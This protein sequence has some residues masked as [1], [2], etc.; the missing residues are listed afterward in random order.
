M[1][2]RFDEAVQ[3]V[4]SSLILEGFNIHLLVKGDRI[5]VKN[6]PINS[7]VEFEVTD[8]IFGR[9]RTPDTTAGDVPIVFGTAIGS[10]PRW[11]DP[12]TNKSIVMNSKYVVFGPINNTRGRPLVKID[13]AVYRTPSA[14]VLYANSLIVD[15]EHDALTA[16]NPVDRVNSQKPED[17]FT[18]RKWLGRQIRDVTSPANMNIGRSD[19]VSRALGGAAEAAGNLVAKR[20]EGKP[21]KPSGWD[22]FAFK[23]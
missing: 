6:S 20:V 2:C 7:I 13:P 11:I 23:K 8:I 15:I 18:V 10:D 21:D 1:N 3:N 22:G 16:N 12:T 4:F 17:K 9:G 5:K 19:I 14:R